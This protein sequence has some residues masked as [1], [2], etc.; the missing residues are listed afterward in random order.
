MQDLGSILSIT[1]KDLCVILP[2]HGGAQPAMAQQRQLAVPRLSTMQLRTLVWMI[3][4]STAVTAL[5]QPHIPWRIMLAMRSAM[6]F[7]LG[8]LHSKSKC[9]E[10]GKEGWRKNCR[11]NKHGLDPRRA[12]S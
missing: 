5:I 9:V 11:K 4:G 7:P 12:F 2:A 3:H 6:V 8:I 1:R 10:E